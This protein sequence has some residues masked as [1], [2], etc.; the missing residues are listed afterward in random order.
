MPRLALAV[1][2]SLALS[3]PAGALPGDFTAEYSVRRDGTRIGRT[4]WTLEHQG[5]GRHRF[6]SVTRATGFLSLF[7][8]GKRT[9][10]SLW[11]WHEG[12]P[13][14]LRYRYLWTGRKGRDVTVDFDW[15]EG[16]ARNIHGDDAWTQDIAPET[17]DKFLYLLV[18]MEDLA[19]GRRPLEYRIA[20]GGRV[21]T[22]RVERRGREVLETPAGRL[23]TVRLFRPDP[24]GK[25][26]TTLWA[27]PALD[28]LPVQVEHRDD[29]ELLR[30]VIEEVEGIPLPR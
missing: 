26:D 2:L 13:R 1:L 12:R 3:L 17:L 28:Y 4:V 7:L 30:M 24:R 14:P 9:E 29:D 25:R 21:K 15:Q 23:E 6:R 20:D 18:M 5:E 10:E 16:T 27:A 11:A 19:A 22:Y 8:S